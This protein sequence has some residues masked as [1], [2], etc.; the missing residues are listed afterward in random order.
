VIVTCNLFGDIITDLG[1][2]L[3]GGLGMAAS[4]NLRPG[5]LGVFE[6]VHGSAPDLAGQ[7]RAN[8]LAAILSVAMMLEHLGWPED[9]RLLQQVV[10]EAVDGA[11]CTADIGGELGTRACG[12]W[13]VK[14]LEERL[15]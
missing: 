14:A 4:A 15:G 2:A 7:D 11:H 9:A 1:A 8:P 3:Q 10:R 12:D 5:G 6:P 13:V